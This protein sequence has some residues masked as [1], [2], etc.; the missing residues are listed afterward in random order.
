MLLRTR[1]RRRGV[2]CW[3]VLD[4]C[5][6]EKVTGRGIVCSGSYCR[7]VVWACGTFLCVVHIIRSHLVRSGMVL[8]V[9]LNVKTK[10]GVE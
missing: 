4:L 2:P 6:Q 1:D 10:E 9:R 5:V 7:L 8:I 3:V